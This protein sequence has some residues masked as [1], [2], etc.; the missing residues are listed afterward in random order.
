MADK[1]K[2]VPQ[3]EHPPGPTVHLG[4]SHRQARGLLRR[5]CY[6]NG[7]CRHELPVSAVSFNLFSVSRIA[8]LLYDIR[9][10]LPGRQQSIV[11]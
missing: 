10:F 6:T 9:V 7:V 8:I 1:G 11:Q 3:H 4:G 5:P 2:H